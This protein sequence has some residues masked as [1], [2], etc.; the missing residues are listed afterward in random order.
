MQELV[1]GRK[2]TVTMKVDC[3]ENTSVMPR[4]AMTSD[5]CRSL[6]HPTHVFSRQRVLHTIRTTTP[7]TD[8]L[9]PHRQAHPRTVPHVKCIPPPSP[10]AKA[11]RDHTIVY[12]TP[13][14]ALRATCRATVKC[15]RRERILLL[16]AARGLVSVGGSL[17]RHSERGCAVSLSSQSP[18]FKSSD[19]HESMS[20]EVRHTPA[21]YPTQVCFSWVDASCSLPQHIVCF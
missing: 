2:G 1:G 17:V 15:E 16:Y 21:M 10:P 7:C 6:L 8:R 19:T 20:A 11:D 14:S 5:F 13:P 12:S 9:R 3:L 4:T 18:D